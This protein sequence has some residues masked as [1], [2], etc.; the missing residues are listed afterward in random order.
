MAT[1]PHWVRHF[2]GFSAPFVHPDVA[3]WCALAEGCGLE[4]R[5]TQV[6]DLSWDFG[7]RAAF[8]Q[9][10]TVGFGAW[11]DRLPAGAATGFVEAVVDA[12]EQ[13]TSEPGVFK[14]MQLRAELASSQHRPGSDHHG[15]GGW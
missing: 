14:F 5:T 13:V 7:S 10:C 6:Q 8:T 4:V 9:W 1:S 12:Y 15:G 2:G 11:T 3:E